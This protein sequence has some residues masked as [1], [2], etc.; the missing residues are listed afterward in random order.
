MYEAQRQRSAMFNDH[1]LLR[2]KLVETQSRG[3]WIDLAGQF[4]GAV[5]RLNLSAGRTVLR[6]EDSPAECLTIE[7]EDGVVLTVE[8]DPALIRVCCSLSRGELDR[9]VA[10]TVR[11]VNGNDATV[12]VDRQTGKIEPD[13]V[14]AESAVR[15]LL[16]TAPVYA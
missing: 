7:R 11:P 3:R 13:S 5:A 10:L 1:L 12:W 14:I 8:Y 4:R 2:A 15:S 16:R 9:T 6:V